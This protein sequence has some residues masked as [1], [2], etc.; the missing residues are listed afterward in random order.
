MNFGKTVAAQAVLAAGSGEGLRFVEGNRPVSPPEILSE[1]ERLDRNVEA[2]GSMLNDLNSCLQPI[3][4]NDVSDTSAL[5]KGPDANNALTPLGRKICTINN[6][7]ENLQRQLDFLR[8]YTA[9]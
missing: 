3:L 2:L 7:L 5:P 1:V 4:P 9:L 8:T 6:R